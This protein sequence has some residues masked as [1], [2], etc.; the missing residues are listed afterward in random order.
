MEKE[1]LRSEYQ[2]LFYPEDLPIVIESYKLVT[3]AAFQIVLEHQKNNT[4]TS[5][6]DIYAG[7]LFQ[8]TVLKSVAILKLAEPINYHND[9]SN[10]DIKGIFDPFTLSNIIR[11][12]YEAFC[13]FNNI[14]INAFSAEELKFKYYLWVISGLKYRQT[15]KA[16]QEDVIIKKQNELLEIGE[17]KTK[18]ETSSVYQSLN[19]ES[20]EKV[21]K[22]IKK[23]KWQ[24]NIEGEN[25]SFLGWHEMFTNAGVNELL[26]GQYTELS[27]KAHPSNVSVFQFGSMY[28]ENTDF[29]TA[30]LSIELSK[31]LISFFISDYCFYFKNAKQ[32]FNQLPI[33]T[34]IL[35]NGYNIMC[36]SEIH[37]TNNISN[38]LN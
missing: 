22:A 34:Q 16:V 8:M 23:K 25:V 36:R 33:M 28:S 13:N 2:R 30:L 38:I 7:H 27:L 32:T 15:F 1:Y 9:I 21:N 10:F 12:Q 17:L 6:E 37:K 24:V 19:S 11:S 35:I 5:P 14:Y 18:I 26:D 4:P 20:K 29:R 31:W 3:D